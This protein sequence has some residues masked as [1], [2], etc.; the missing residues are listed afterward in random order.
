MEVGSELATGQIGQRSNEHGK[1]CA[2]GSADLDHWIH[3]HLGRRPEQLR[4]EAREPSHEL[5][6]RRKPG[7]Q[8]FVHAGRDATDEPLPGGKP[9]G[10]TAGR[11]AERMAARQFLPI[12]RI[13]SWYTIRCRN[14]AIAAI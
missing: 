12:W 8:R 13:I 9:H 5:L 3:R 1:G 2:A 11:G 10:V 6:A 7:L 14:G 4:T